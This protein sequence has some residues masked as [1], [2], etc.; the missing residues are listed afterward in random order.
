MLVAPVATALGKSSP[1]IRFL[2]G[3]QRF[4]KVLVRDLPRLESSARSF[5]QQLGGGCPGILTNAP[6]DEQFGT[7]GNETLLGLLLAS[8]KPADGAV[9]RFDREIA[10]L[11]WSDHKLTRLVRTLRDSNE[12]QA[13]LA[14]PN[15]CADIQ[16]WAGSG[17]RTVP[18]SAEAFIRS[19]SRS[20]KGPDTKDVLKALAPHENDSAR[21]LATAIGKLRDEFMKSGLVNQLKQDF[22]ELA[23]MLGASS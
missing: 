20:E 4:D 17:Y 16:S 10:H 14:L 15:V 9:R 18:T 22:K 7:F 19:E 23:Q 5:A 11:R 6:R 8:T 13:K 1:T 21:H 2:R 12:A 3:A